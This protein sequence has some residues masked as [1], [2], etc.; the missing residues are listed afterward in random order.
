MC[1]S[2]SVCVSVSLSLSLSLCAHVSGEWAESAC[3]SESVAVRV[4]LPFLSLLYC[5]WFKD[6]V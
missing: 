3:V 4:S 5:L 6:S 1:A 2:L